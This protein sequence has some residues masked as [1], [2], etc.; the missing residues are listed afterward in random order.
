MANEKPRI[1]LDPGH[2]KARYNQGAVPGYWEG[3]RMWRLYQLLRPA[4]EK[5]GFI[6]GG[7][8]SKCDQALSVTQRGR[9]AK[10]YDLL[11]SL[12]SNACGDPAVDR[13]VGIYL[14]DDNC[15][16]IDEDSRVLSKLLS[17]TVASV[18][19]TKGKAEQY[20]RKSDL[21]RDHDGLR[22]DDYYGV[23][24]SAHQAGVAALILEHS[25]H[26]N[27]QAAAWLLDDDNLA[28]LAEAEA[29]ALAKHYGMSGGTSSSAPTTEKEGFPVKM[30]SIKRG[31]KH[32]HVRVLQALL[33]GLNYKADDG[34]TLAV[35]GSY[36]PKTEQA[37]EKYQA[38][39]KDTDGKPLTRDGKCGPKTWGSILEQ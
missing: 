21:D 27:P 35:D 1:L 24:H 34:S 39:N 14:V 20:S 9:M 22:N 30:E 25:F 6:V 10:G 38:K 5:R 28:K 19:G 12:H 17:S 3:G 33:R 11:L 16:P 29:D 2:D 37:V 13:P 32:P 15:G 8:K 26:T 18:M 36:G 31:S 4:L 23:L 7:T